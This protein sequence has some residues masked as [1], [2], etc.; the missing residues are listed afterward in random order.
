ML[1][2]NIAVAVCLAFALRASGSEC[3]TTSI[4]HVQG[5]REEVRILAPAD[6]DKLI[7]FASEAQTVFVAVRPLSKEPKAFRLLVDAKGMPAEAFMQVCETSVALYKHDDT[8]LIRAD[9]PEPSARWR[10]RIFNPDQVALGIVVY[11]VPT[12]RQPK[13]YPVGLDFVCI[14]SRNWGNVPSLSNVF[15]QDV[16]PVFRIEDVAGV[17]P[18]AVVSQIG[19]EFIKAVESWNTAARTT[20]L[21][22]VVAGIEI[23]GDRHDFINARLAKYLTAFPPYDPKSFVSVAAWRD[24][25]MDLALASRVPGSDA[26]ID[27]SSFV[28][29]SS[30]LRSKICDVDPDAFYLGELRRAHRLICQDTASRPA[31]TVRLVD[32]ISPIPRCTGEGQI[33]FGCEL[34][35][36]GVIELNIGTFVFVSHA[37]DAQLFGKGDQSIDF[38][39]VSVHELGHLLGLEHE[40]LGGTV[41][42]M[43]PYPAMAACLDNDVRNALARAQERLMKSGKSQHQSP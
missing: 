8:K 23:G 25:D 18:P 20:G 2:R 26:W 31:L 41:T 27:S 38:L 15:F 1:L 39:L 16:A 10:I 12:A 3:A 36:E 30:M 19:G 37:E 14:D 33:P 21:G 32:K 40:D 7:F 22:T 43:S 34:L 24:V 4:D 5:A 11:V 9:S 29:L 42:V 13:N 17:L 28:P 6:Q 35:G